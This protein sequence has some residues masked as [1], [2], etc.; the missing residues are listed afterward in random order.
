MRVATA[1]MARGRVAM[2][3]GNLHSAAQAFAA[4]LPVLDTHKLWRVRL[5]AL[6]T[7]LAMRQERL[8]EAQR[9]IEETLQRQRVDFS[10]NHPEL[11]ATYEWLAVVHA[12]AG[13]LDTARSNIAT[14]CSIRAHSRAANH[15]QLIRCDAYAAL[16][17][18]SAT[19]VVKAEALRSL[20]ATVTLG[21][22]DHIALIPALYAT[23]KRL[24][25]GSNVGTTTELFPILD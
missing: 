25:A 19:P 6:R 18:G 17:N 9:I 14:S 23:A 10:S 22:R 1:Q 5:N 16:L 20:I 2:S 4:A 13:Q 8:P 21:R 24:D 15:P 11:A 3:A 12:R 7:E